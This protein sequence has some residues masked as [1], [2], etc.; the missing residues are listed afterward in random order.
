MWSTL[1]K[2]GTVPVPASR[3]QDAAQPSCL[4][5]STF[6]S[7]PSLLSVPVHTY[8]A[9]LSLLMRRRQYRGSK[10]EP[11]LHRW[12]EILFQ[13]MII[14]SSVADP[15]HFDADPDPACHLIRIRILLRMQI[16]I[17]L[18]MFMWMRIRMLPFRLL[19][20]H[21][22]PDPDPQHW[23]PLQIFRNCSMVAPH[24]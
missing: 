11:L 16:R 9:P 20:I 4:R 10:G 23:F 5:I 8:D 15:N 1:P 13:F 2:F 12:R 14:P 17:Q 24:S 19:R 22:N 18:I 7:F 3:C 6:L 21:A